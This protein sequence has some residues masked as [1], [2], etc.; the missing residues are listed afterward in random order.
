MNKVQYVKLLEIRGV[1]DLNKGETLFGAVERT[2][3]DPT[4]AEMV[5]VNQRAMDYYIG[6]F[7]EERKENLRLENMMDGKQLVK[8]SAISWLYEN[9]QEVYNEFY[10]KL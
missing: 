6:K 1:A 7:D 4:E 5:L 10:D 2:G 9:H 8:E 3:G